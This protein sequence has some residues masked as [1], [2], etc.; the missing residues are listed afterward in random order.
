MALFSTKLLW[1]RKNL[2]DLVL[3]FTL[4]FIF[5]KRAANLIRMRKIAITTL[6][7]A[8]GF[9]QQTLQKQPSTRFLRLFI[10]R[11]QCLS[12]K[13]QKRTFIRHVYL[14]STQPFLIASTTA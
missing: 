12:P 3:T 14:T 9:L 5:E 10:L 7:S 13:K 4:N 1:D 8:F 2:I 6:K 11:E